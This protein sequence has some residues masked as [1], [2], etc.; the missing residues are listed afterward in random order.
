MR[1]CLEPVPFSNDQKKSFEINRIQPE[2][3]ACPIPLGACL[4]PER[5][6]KKKPILSRIGP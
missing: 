3:L 2:P 5:I 4:L 6:G 1:F